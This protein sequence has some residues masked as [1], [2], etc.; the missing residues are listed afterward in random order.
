MTFPARFACLLAGLIV[1]PATVIAQQLEPNGPQGPAVTPPAPPV[2]EEGVAAVTEDDLLRHWV[3]HSREVAAW[4]TQIGEAR[5]D[6]VTATLWPNPVLSINVMGTPAGTPPDGYFNVGGQLTAPLPVLGQLDARGNAARAQIRVAEV[7][8][9]ATLWNRAGDIQDSL[10]ARAFADASAQVAQRNV[11][12]MSRLERIVENRVAAG[13]NGEYDAVRV[14]T[15]MATLRAALSNAL[16]ERQRQESRIVA[17]VADP[18]L[19][20]A[21]VTRA[22]LAAFRGPED[23][24]RL[25]QMALRRRPDLM[26]AERSVSAYRAVAAR[27]RAEVVPVPSLWVGAYGSTYNGQSAGSPPTSAQD[28]VSVIGGIAFALPITDQNQGLVGRAEID[29]E[30][31]QALGDALRA[32]IRTEVTGAWRARRE[33]RRAL[34][35]FRRGGLVAAAQ[36]LSRAEVSYQAGG[37]GASQFTIADLLDAYR[38]AWDAR[39]QELALERTFAEAEVDLE[40]ATALVPP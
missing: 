29:V 8:V 5:F 10:I 17:L 23:E 38:T 1:S 35:E 40:H 12:E 27:W 28:S 25:V 15:A 16:V 4:R 14:Q 18:E 9:L 3:Q 2:A 7:S 36:V 33:A 30:Q 11:D 26:L 6:L 24:A 32:R 39:A 37:S 13:A 19:V 34:D 31:Q 22:S 21:P 20:A